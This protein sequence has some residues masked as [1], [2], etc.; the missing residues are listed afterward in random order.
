M[1]GFKGLQ[2]TKRAVNLARPVLKIELSLWRSTRKVIA[3]PPTLDP[4]MQRRWHTDKMQ[5]KWKILLVEDD[6]FSHQYV[7]LALGTD[8]EIDWQQSVLEGLNALRAKEFDLIILDR[9]LPDGDGL[10]I[11]QEIKLHQSLSVPVIILSG[12]TEE[13]DHVVGFYAG[14]VDYIAKPFRPLEFKARVDARVKSKP[15]SISYAGIRV[16]L[17]TF[18]AYRTDTR[19]TEEVNLTRIEMKILICFLESVDSIFPREQL[20]K[21]VWGGNM[22]VSDRTVDTHISHLRKKIKEAGIAITFIYGEGY[23]LE[24]P[25]R[26]NRNS[27]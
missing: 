3:P 10:A 16:D 8:Y 2:L 13:S 21:K 19:E 12:Q 6:G 22:N 7:K 5:V 20:L 24:K 14:A 1:G 4:L 23:R 17:K 9:Q 25:A 18:R 26:S 27:A 11:C 15:D